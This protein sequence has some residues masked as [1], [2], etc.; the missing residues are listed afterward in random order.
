MIYKKEPI[1]I[2]W[3]MVKSLATKI[4]IYKEA[5]SEDED[6]TPQSYLLL[7]SEVTDGSS[8]FGDGVSLIREA[9]CDFIFFTKGIATNSTDKHNKNKA[10]ITK[11]LKD[12]GFAFKTYNIGYIESLKSTQQTWSGKISYIS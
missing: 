1:L 11:A 2:M 10:D 9:D 12:A 8:A 4:P 6:S 3:D 5:M 7:R